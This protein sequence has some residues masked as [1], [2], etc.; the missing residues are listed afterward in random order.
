[1]TKRC[2]DRIIKHMAMHI[3]ARQ[4]EC[5]ITDGYVLN[6]WHDFKP[7]AEAGY[8]A[9]MEVDAGLVPL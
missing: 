4:N 1:M 7:A 8:K 9:M 6:H 2:I 5:K 3:C